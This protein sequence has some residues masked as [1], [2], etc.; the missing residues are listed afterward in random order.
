MRVEL[1]RKRQLERYQGKRLF[2]NASL[3]G[4]EIPVY[5]QLD[6]QEE[7]MMAQAFDRLSLTVRTYHKILKVARTI[8]DLDGEEKIRA[9]HLQEALIYRS[10]DR[11]YWGMDDGRC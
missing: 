6:K 2:F 8:A 7:R 4:A 3:S 5:C 1:A 9:E 11:K 10:I